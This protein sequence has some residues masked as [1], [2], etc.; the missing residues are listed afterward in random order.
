MLRERS[1]TT[2]LSRLLVASLC[3]SFMVC[4]RPTLAATE[5]LQVALLSPD[6]APDRSDQVLPGALDAARHRPLPAHLSAAGDRR[7]RRRRPA[8]RQARQP[9]PARPRALAA[10]H[11]RE[12]SLDLRRARGVARAATPTIPAPIGST[13]WRCAG[14][15][16]ARRRRRGRC[17]AISAAT[18]RRARSWSGSTTARR[19]T[20]RRPRT[21]R[22]ATGAS[23]STSWSA[24][25]SR[26]TAEA[27]LQ[28]P[29]IV[30]LI[31]R[32]EADLARWTVARGY[33]G[34]GNYGRALDPRRPRRHPLG[35]CRPGDALDRRPQRLASGPDPGCGL[36]FLGARGCALDPAWRALAG[37]L[38]GGA[39]L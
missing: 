31:D 26:T 24:P 1:T 14:S 27:E 9:L 6:D 7:S 29:E 16:P 13:A 4:P 3:A 37:G 5:T 22:C 30:V 17:A 10:L 32:V 23:G 11:V 2:L 35:R 19:S 28:R 15:R 39:R 12:L 34:A 38:L 8:D 25:A 36:A 20:A 33:L 21:P 18:A